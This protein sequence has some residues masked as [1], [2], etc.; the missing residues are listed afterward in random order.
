M[1][2]EI[3]TRCPA[4]GGLNRS[5]SEWC[6]QC[7]ASLAGPENAPAPTTST[8]PNSTDEPQGRRAEDTRSVPDLGEQR[9][10]PGPRGGVFRVEEG[11][12]VSWQCGQC[13]TTNS[14]D[15]DA[16]TACGTSFVTTMKPD[17]PMG[18]E[19][20]PGTAAMLSLFM[21][22]SGHGYLGLW[23]QAVARAVLGL[24][25]SG[26]VLLAGLQDGAGS[27]LIAI[28]F[29]AASF[30]LWIVTAHDAYREAGHDP[31]AVILK[32]RLFLYTV[33]ALLVILLGMLI[34]SGLR[35][36]AA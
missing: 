25:V 18:P 8:R 29:G 6:G 33:L 1:S 13:S 3:S 23:G 14:L 17:E 15:A 26:I 27:G 30:G 24:W 4:C 21:P 32:G 12:G 31:G 34:L 10:A 5:D 28:V 11:G 7:F 19:R 16:C 9:A 22:G 20:D 36:S 35:A 2:T